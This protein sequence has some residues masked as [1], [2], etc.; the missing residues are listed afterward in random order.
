MLVETG[1][2]DFIVLVIT[3]LLK[4]IELLVFDHSQLITSNRF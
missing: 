2:E 1:L 4:K 3:L